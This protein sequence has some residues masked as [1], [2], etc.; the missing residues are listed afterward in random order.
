M[1][2]KRAIIRYLPVTGFA[3]AMLAFYLPWID[4]PAAALAPNALDL[5]E[6]TSLHPAV[7]AESPALLTTFFLRAVAAACGVGLVASAWWGW[8]PGLAIA[9]V[10][11]PP[12]DFFRDAGGDLNFRQQFA[13][14]MVTAALVVIAAGL[15]RRFTGRRVRAAL[16][17]LPATAGI[18]A[19]AGGLS[20]AK[21][22]ID[23][24]Y[25]AGVGVGMPL[26]VVGLALALIGATMRAAQSE[27]STVVGSGVGV[28][29]GVGSQAGDTVT[30]TG[31]SNSESV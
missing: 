20:R 14:A 31:A 16:I 15:R 7:R 19:A 10:L 1:T 26:A 12:L 21:P 25:S 17:A 27:G 3:L 6:W 4:H 22:L 23:A 24:M 5:A 2:A 11:V 29:V 30:S 8:L 28:G 9:G 18:A 13:L